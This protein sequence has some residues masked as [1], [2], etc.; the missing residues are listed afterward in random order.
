MTE[1]LIRSPWLPAPTY[2][3]E[4]SFLPRLMCG[5]TQGSPMLTKY[6]A[7]ELNIPRPWNSDLVYMHGRTAVVDIPIQHL[8]SAG[9]LH[10]YQAV[11]CL[12]W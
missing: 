1:Q 5:L 4:A 10:S 11:F 7:T 3:S 2:L 8:S 9:S 12:M 6:S